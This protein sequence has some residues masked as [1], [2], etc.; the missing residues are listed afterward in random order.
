M[1]YI[2]DALQKSEAE[3]RRGEVPDINRPLQMA[4]GSKRKRGL[5][6]VWV[7]VA[8][9]INALVLGVIF[10][11]EAG[12]LLPS[13]TDAEVR[14]PVEPPS[15]SRRSAPSDQTVTSTASQP[16]S[17]SPAPASP[18]QTQETEPDP[19]PAPQASPGSQTGNEPAVET[20]TSGDQPS[21]DKP[22]LIVPSASS[23]GD[24]SGW[25]PSA[26][27]PSLNEMPLS[28]QRD[29]PDLRFSSHVYASDPDARRVMINGHYLR[30]G[31]RFSGVRVEG[32][33]ENGVVLFADGERFRVGVVRDWSSPQ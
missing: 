4:Q 32:I 8:L 17:V 12:S 5:G 24:G 25:Q 21:G 30:P 10:W 18:P 15:E 6:V 33:T 13:S 29:I 1:S 22:T 16:T 23:K 7:A 19:V 27:V 26:S 9:L 31:D 20:E 14:P 3:R 2:L 11:P 28:F